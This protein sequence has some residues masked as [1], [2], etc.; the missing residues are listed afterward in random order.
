MRA[1]PQTS[2]FVLAAIYGA[3][4]SFILGTVWGYY[5][6]NHLFNQWLIDSLLKNGYAVAYYG[7]IYTHDLLLNMI[8]ALPFAYLI[9][10]LQPRYN[11]LLLAAALMVAVS[12]VYWPVLIRPRSALFVLSD[13]TGF[14]PFAVLVSS[15]PIGFSVLKMSNRGS[16]D[17][18]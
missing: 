9:G 4:F 15:L 6:A 13:W 10:R 14:V 3:L 1:R 2:S 18:G 11:W 12:V 5:G 17:A 16:A 7:A 8:I